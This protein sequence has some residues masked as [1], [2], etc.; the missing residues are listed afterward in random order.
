MVIETIPQ[1]LFFFVALCGAWALGNNFQEVI[2][3]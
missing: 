2:D 3:S 1:F